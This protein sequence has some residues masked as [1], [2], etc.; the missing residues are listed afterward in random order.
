MCLSD[1]VIVYADDACSTSGI[2]L[3]SL[4]CGDAEETGHDAWLSISVPCD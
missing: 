1:S 2:T 3:G 4:H